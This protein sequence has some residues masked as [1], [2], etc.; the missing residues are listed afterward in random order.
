M[1]PRWLG[2][3]P[4]GSARLW[5]RPVAS[6]QPGYPFFKQPASTPISTPQK[7]CQNSICRSS[8]LLKESSASPEDTPDL[9]RPSAAP[10]VIIE[11][12]ID[13]DDEA[14]VPDKSSS[15]NVKSTHGSSKQWESPPV[16]R[17]HGLNTQKPASWGLA[18]CPVPRGMSGASVT[19]LRRG[20]IT[21]RC[22]T[23]HLLP[24]VRAGDGH[25]REVLIRST[26]PLTSIPSASFGQA[27]PKLQDHLQWNHPL[28]ATEPEERRPLLEKGHGPGESFKA[29]SLRFWCAGGPDPVEVPKVTDPSQGPWC[30][31]SQHGEHREVLGFPWLDMPMDQEFR[32]WDTNLRCL[33]AVAVKEVEHLTMVL[34]LNEDHT[35]YSDAF[36]NIFESGALS[37][38]R[39]PEGLDGIKTKKGGPA[40]SDCVSLLSAC[41]FKWWLRLSSSGCHTP[42]HSMGVRSVS[43]IHERV[44]VENKGACSVSPKE[45]LQRAIPLVPQ[46]GGQQTFWLILGQGVKWRGGFQCGNQKKRKSKRMTKSAVP[47]VGLAQTTRILSRLP[48]RASWNEL[49]VAVPRDSVLNTK[50]QLEIA[51]L[52]VFTFLF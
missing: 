2:A 6:T 31:S 38:K 47:L 9:T 1:P 7:G 28:A 45:E 16:Q 40:P 34:V 18:R 50:G 23:S 8:P 46:E 22:D 12:V 49:Q 20:L 27:V 48:T 25:I 14:S 39:F 44:S 51:T 35:H 37:K 19:S 41:L 17:R 42:Q 29:I 43:R 13:D 52:R 32:R 15:S 26:S 33:K 11:D 30:D 36:G 10:S 5:P 3:Q 24:C 21:S 4:L